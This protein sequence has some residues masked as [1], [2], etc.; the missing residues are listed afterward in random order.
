MRACQLDDLAR[1]VVVFDARGDVKFLRRYAHAQR[2][3]HCV[4][5]DHQVAGVIA[6]ESCG[7]ALRSQPWVCGAALVCCNF[8]AVRLVIYAVL[9]LGRRALATKCI[10]VL[11][12]GSFGWSFFLC[13]AHHF[14]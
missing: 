4:A 5:A 2:F 3:E 9:G 8:G 11:A 10:A 14:T 1:A 13:H 7:A 6:G 12:A